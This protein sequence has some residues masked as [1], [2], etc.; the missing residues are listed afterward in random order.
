MASIGHFAGNGA[1]LLHCQHNGEKSEDNYSVY[2]GVWEGI[3]YIESLFY[4][5]SIVCK[6]ARLLFK[7][8]HHRFLICPFIKSCRR[9]FRGHVPVR[10]GG[11]RRLCPGHASKYECE[12][13]LAEGDATDY[14]L[15]V[16][17]KK[18]VFFSTAWKNPFF[19]FFPGFFSRK[20]RFSE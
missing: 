1:Q 10:S 8:S 6:S 14:E 11:G 18:N 7:V 5:H 17:L 9:G 19:P 12:I 4:C 13:W 20:I 16:F 15:L 3:S 2:V